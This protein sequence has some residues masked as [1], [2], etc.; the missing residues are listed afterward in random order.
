APAPAPAQAGVVKKSAKVCRFFG[1]PEGCRT[2]L[3]CQFIHAQVGVTTPAA[4]V[5]TTEAPRPVPVPVPVPAVAVAAPAPVI[6]HAPAG[7]H[8]QVSK[9][10]ARV[11]M[12]TLAP[13]EPAPA[14]IPAPAPASAPAKCSPPSTLVAP[15]V[16]G[17]ETGAGAGAGAEEERE[18][19]CALLADLPVKVFVKPPVKP[20]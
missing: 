10:R 17:C 4:L 12:A 11:A 2:G 19:T 6:A 13:A 1:K 16:N 5:A 7:H 3:D 18:N 8:T 15:V 9:K 20:A 14:P